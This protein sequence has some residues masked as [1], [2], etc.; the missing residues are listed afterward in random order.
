MNLPFE[1]DHNVY[2]LGAGFSADAGLPLVSD[3]L[4]RMRDC[5]PWLIEKGRPNE[6]KAVENVLRFR[7]EAASAA[8]WVKLDLENR[9]ELFSLASARAGSLS[10][11]IPVA[12]ASTI[13]Y[14]LKSGERQAR[15]A[16]IQGLP[17]AGRVPWLQQAA[18]RSLDIFNLRTFPHYVAKL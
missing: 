1:N 14:A 11:D 3:F 16:K 2:I 10:D 15:P 17:I 13:D 9:E 4:L 6:A 8:Y 18:G 5:H 12:V 7:L